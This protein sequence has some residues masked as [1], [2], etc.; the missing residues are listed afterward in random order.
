MFGQRRSRKR[1][2]GKCAPAAPSVTFRTDASGRPCVHVTGPPGMC[3]TFDTGGDTTHPAKRVQGLCVG[4]C[5]MVPVVDDDHTTA[6]KGYGFVVGVDTAKK[7]VRF[8]W[9]YNGSEMAGLGERGIAKGTYT[10]TNHLEDTTVDEATVVDFPAATRQHAYDVYKRKSGVLVSTLKDIAASVAN[11]PDYFGAGH[12]AACAALPPQN[13][14]VLQ[15]LYAS[16]LWH[17][18]PA[19]VAE[20][21]SSFCTD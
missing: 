19:H 15:T 7:S 9:L 21:V 5:V 14:R 6:S 8:V 4:S 2:A 12:G 11:K 18:E 13:R 17:S 1:G 10:V 3:V 16:D 20:V